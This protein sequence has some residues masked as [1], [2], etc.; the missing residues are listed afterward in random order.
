MRLTL[1]AVLLCLSACEAQREFTRVVQFTAVT[2]LVLGGNHVY[3]SED[4]ALKRVAKTG[5]AIE[6]LVTADVVDFAA[7]TGHAYAATNAGLLHVT[8]ATNGTVAMTTTLTNEPVISVAA[9]GA[10]VS[11]L[12]CT[13]VTHAAHDGSNPIRV[14]TT[15]PCGMG[16]TTRITLDS[17]TVYGMDPMGQWMSSRAG[18]PI[19]P[20]ANE[21]CQRIEA[22]GGWLYCSDRDAGLRRFSPRVKEVE[23]VLDG[24]VH[25]FALGATRVYAGVGQDLISSPR[26]TSTQEVLGTYAAI[27]AIVLDEKDVYFV[28]TEGNLGLLLRTPQ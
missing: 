24:Q 4:R 25:T 1:A 7:A 18:G 14:P 5:G 28:N 16:G 23:L 26:N 15:R 8:L 19:T 2:K 20:L 13:A 22:G 11:W 12:T 27:S 9:D 17:S 6:V 21:K 10:G 3:F